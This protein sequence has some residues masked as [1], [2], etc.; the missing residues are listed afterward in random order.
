MIAALGW[1]WRGGVL[2]ILAFLIFGPLAN[3]VL[4]AVA[5]QWYFPPQI[6]AD[7]WLA[8]LGRGL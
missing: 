7:L 3:L 6:A 4:W 1:L 8:V 5:I 2:G